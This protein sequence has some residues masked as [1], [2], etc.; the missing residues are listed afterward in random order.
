MVEAL[1]A[2]GLGKKELPRQRKDP[3]GAKKGERRMKKI[4]PVED[5]VMERIEPEEPTP[6]AVRQAKIQRWHDL[7]NG[8]PECEICP[9]MAECLPVEIKEADAE[10]LDRINGILEAA[11]STQAP[12]Q[13][14]TPAEP[15]PDP[16]P[17]PYSPE[18]SAE[19]DEL[20]ITLNDFCD[21]RLSCRSC[22]MSNCGCTPEVGFMSLPT[23]T[24]RKW[25]GL[26]KAA[27]WVASELEMAP[28]EPAPAPQDDPVNHPS[29]YTQG[30]IECLDAIKASMS[31]EEYAGMLKGQVLKYVWRY[32]LKGQPAQD[33]KKAQFYLGRLIEEVEANAEE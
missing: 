26:I 9:A 7:C 29:H 25:V 19:R 22:P 31:P 33:L 18:E 16:E 28:T 15:V 23:N 24:L 10:T 1:L 11:H 32:R 8:E 14:E 27:K 17:A 12:S 13:P 20:V 2:A 5:E 6:E 21:D 4:R 30:G 3:R